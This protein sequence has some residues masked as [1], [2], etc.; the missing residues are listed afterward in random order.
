[1]KKHKKAILVFVLL[2]VLLI[3]GFFLLRSG[4]NYF[5][6]KAYPTQYSTI[7]EK[8]AV[9]NQ[10]K[11]A[12]VYSVIKAE[13]NFQPEAKS[14]AGAYGLMQLMP[15]TFEW[16]QTKVE[17][18][19]KFTA[20]D[21]FVPEVNIRY[22][23]KYLSMMLK[24]FKN[25][26]TAICAYN[27]GAGAVNGWLK[28]SSYSKDGLTLDNIPFPETERYAQAV[29]KNYDIYNKLYQFK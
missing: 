18:K 5:M 23:C 25:E 4:Y 24:E 15:S 27:A 10:L 8:E 9:K 11:P 3:A 1:M 2:L 13:S 26:K 6:K 29:L 17:S 16:L 28:N 20:E 19:T 12:L 7:V 14:R 21:L 22:G